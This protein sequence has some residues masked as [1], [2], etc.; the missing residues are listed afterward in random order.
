MRIS[1]WSSDVGSSDLSAMLEVTSQDAA[2]GSRTYVVRGQV[3]FASAVQFANSF[4]YLHAS[5]QVLIDLTQ[6]HFWDTSAVP[7][8]DRVVLKLD[9]K[10]V[11]SGTSVS[12]R[13]DLGGR[14]LIP[15]QQIHKLV[16]IQT[17]IEHNVR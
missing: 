7:A 11:V 10:S 16:D 14:R 6:A 2:D 1:D 12:V 8:L 5:R 13:V 4:D 17:I 9:R 15:T 3:F